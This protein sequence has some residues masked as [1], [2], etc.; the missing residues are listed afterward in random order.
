[1]RKFQIFEV[2]TNS[3]CVAEG[4]GMAVVH[5]LIEHPSVIAIIIASFILERRIGEVMDLIKTG[6]VEMEVRLD[7]LENAVS[8]IEGCRLERDPVEEPPP[9]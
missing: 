9:Y 1:M 8:L 5:W 3:V 6:R 4:G 7:N 2:D